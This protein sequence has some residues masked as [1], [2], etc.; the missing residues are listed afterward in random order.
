MQDDPF[1]LKRFLAAQMPVFDTVMAELGRGRKETDWMWFIFPQLRGPDPSETSQRQGIDSIEE[2]RAYLAH[3]VLGRRLEFATEAV[4]TADPKSVKEIFGSPDD[5]HFHASMS[6]FDAADGSA[7]S[8]FR[9]ALS[10]WFAGA[11]HEG[12]RQ[13]LDTQQAAAAARLRS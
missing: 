13:I 9:S 10:R 7:F 5:L 8:P 4:L 3:R 2:A 1:E 11:P 12:T 6:L